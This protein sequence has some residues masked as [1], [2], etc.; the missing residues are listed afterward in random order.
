[1]RSPD[2][3]KG[4]LADR[5]RGLEVTDEETEEDLLEIEQQEQMPVSDS[6]Q[7]T[8]QTK[9]T[10]TGRDG[11]ARVLP[12]SEDGNHHTNTTRAPDVL[13]HEEPKRALTYQVSFAEVLEKTSS[14]YENTFKYKIPMYPRL[15]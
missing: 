9:F 7:S 4:L 3:R 5:H 14:S 10:P 11:A 8:S 1:M 15:R 12:H 2:R 13:S 6:P